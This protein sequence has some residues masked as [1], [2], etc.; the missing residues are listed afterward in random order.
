LVPEPCLGSFVP[1]LGQQVHWSLVGCSPDKLGMPSP[2]DK[3]VITLSPTP[4]QVPSNVKGISNR[5]MGYQDFSGINIRVPAVAQWI[6]IQRKNKVVSPYIPLQAGYRSK[7]Q[8]LTHIWL[9]AT[10]LATLLP[11]LHDLLSFVSLLCHP[12]P[13]ATL[14][15]HR[16]ACFFFF[17]FGPPPCYSRT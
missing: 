10:L 3:E 5:H 2:S 16:L 9:R 17:F 1:S 14:S 8:G 4:G 6:H 15:E 7:K 11:V 12:L 13:P